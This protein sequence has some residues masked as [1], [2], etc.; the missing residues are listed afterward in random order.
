MYNSFSSTAITLSK[1]DCTK[2]YTVAAT[3]YA[4]CGFGSPGAIKLVSQFFCALAAEHLA[5]VGE[6]IML[7]ICRV[8]RTRSIRLTSL[9]SSL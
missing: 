3:P 4:T 8:R 7:V 5:I 1:K 2:L 9:K 6:L